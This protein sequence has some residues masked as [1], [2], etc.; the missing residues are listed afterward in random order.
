MEGARSQ[1]RRVVQ[2]LVSAWLAGDDESLSSACTPDVRWW[3]P[4]ADGPTSGPTDAGA[5]LRQVLGPLPQPVTVTAVVPSDDG[6][7]CVVEMRSA[8][9][10]HGP[11]AFVTSVL[12]LR[13]GRIAAGRTYSDLPQQGRTAEAS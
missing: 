5:A 13:D 6:S 1:A 10:Q 8:V 7:R 4:L 11:P 9:A 12:T 2:K 3:T